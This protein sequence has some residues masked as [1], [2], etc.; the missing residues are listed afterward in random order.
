MDR[1]RC[2]GMMLVTTLALMIGGCS[3]GSGLEF[4]AFGS[5]LDSDD[6][7]DGYGGGVKAELNPIDMI[8]VDARASWIHFDD[9]DIDMV[10]LELAGLLNFPI[11]WEH[12]VP[13]I[14][15]GVGYY[16]FDGS[17]A[18]LDDE[19]GFFPLA[20]LEIGLHSVSVLAEARW[21]FLETDVEGAEDELRNLTE[22]DV[23][24]L[25]VN[26]GLLFRF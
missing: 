18:D 23:D 19:V 4:G 9:T 11:L 25:G 22:A 6:L 14:G 20:G 21:L 16:L 10:P 8:S 15:A 13:Y 3:H 24:G 1:K 12:I 2:S 26:L 5:S 17:G 7:G